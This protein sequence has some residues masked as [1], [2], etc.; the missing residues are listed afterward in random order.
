LFLADTSKQNSLSI[1]SV[2]KLSVYEQVIPLTVTIQ[3]ECDPYYFSFDAKLI[4]KVKNLSFFTDEY[5]PAGQASAHNPG[6]LSYFISR[7]S[8]FK[9]ALTS[10]S[11]IG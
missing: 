1:D 10:G 3:T 6:S 9:S 2:W 7:K 4:S 5:L 8:I 11:K